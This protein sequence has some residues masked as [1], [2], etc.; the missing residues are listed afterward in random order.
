MAGHSPQH[1]SLTGKELNVA[2]LALRQK[3]QLLQHFLTGARKEPDGSMIGRAGESAAC[4]DKPRVERQ[5]L[6]DE[7]PE[8]QALWKA[9]A[10]TDDGNRR[11]KGWDLLVEIA[12]SKQETDGVRVRLKGA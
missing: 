3:V 7:K 10:L 1:R 4:D 5:A 9:G 12:V 6:R 2:A 8:Y 11:P